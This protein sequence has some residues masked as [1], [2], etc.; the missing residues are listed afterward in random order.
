MKY[1]EVPT[2]EN[3]DPRDKNTRWK[4]LDDLAEINAALTKYN[5]Q[6][7]HQAQGTPFT[8]FPLSDDFQ[9]SGLTHNTEALTMQ[10]YEPSTILPTCVRD[11]LQNMET[12]CVEIDEPNVTR[13]DMRSAFAKWRKSTSNSSVMPAP[14]VPRCIRQQH[15]RHRCCQP[16]Q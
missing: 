1:I 13:E 15:P 8:V 5:R 2:N 9:H 16:L 10:Q 14:S 7:F 3:D 11:L 4:R 6:H 12:K